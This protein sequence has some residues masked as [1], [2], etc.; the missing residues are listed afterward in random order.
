MVQFDALATRRG[1]NK[2]GSRDAASPW[3]Q[4]RHAICKQ[5]KRQLAA[6]KAARMKKGSRPLWLRLVSSS[7]ALACGCSFPAADSSLSRRCAHRFNDETEA[8]D[9]FDT[10]RENFVWRRR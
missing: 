4:A 8:L 9:Y 2:T 7:S 10:P 1:Q 3:A 5:L 6:G